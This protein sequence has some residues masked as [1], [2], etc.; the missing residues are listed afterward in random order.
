MSAAP[1]V[2]AIIIFL[3][4]EV[5]LGDAIASVLA[6]TYA[7]WELL[8][9]DDGSTDGSRDIARRWAEAHPDKIFYLEHGGH[10]NRGTSASRNLGIQDAR[11]EFVAFLDADDIWLP[12]KLI[13]Q[14]GVMDAHPDAGMVC[15]ASMYSANWEADAIAPRTDDPTP[16]GGPQDR[17][18][19]PPDLLTTLYPLGNGA[20]PCPS[21]LLLRRDAVLQ[22]GGFEESFRGNLQLYED[23]VF[24][25]KIYLACGVFVCSKV[26]DIY[27]LRKN[28]CVARV[29]GAGKYHAVRRAYLEWLER[30]LATAHV[31]YPDVRKALRAALFR[32]RHPALFALFHACLN[33]T[34]P[35]RKWC[36]DHVLSS[37]KL[38]AL[39]SGVAWLRL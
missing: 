1:R 39:R 38:R 15:G 14:I 5:L 8:L 33:V 31:D 21:G 37:D 16:V 6:Q 25:S 30:H 13:Y 32:Y 20:A 27:R 12:E 11:G 29:T 4:E 18:V 17:V 34:R 3:N 10:A 24:L 26:L 35:G 2:S 23:Q 36:I 19:K 28:S 9:V 22:I 7:D